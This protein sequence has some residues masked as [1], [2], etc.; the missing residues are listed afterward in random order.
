MLLLQNGTE[1]EGE[2]QIDSGAF[3]LST[4]ETGIALSEEEGEATP[5]QD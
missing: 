5:T 2:A 1:W 3:G 4:S